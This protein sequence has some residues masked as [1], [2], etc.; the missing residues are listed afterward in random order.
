MLR[1]LD[2]FQFCQCFFKHP[3]LEGEFLRAQHKENL[4]LRFSITQDKGYLKKFVCNLETCKLS[5]DVSHD[6]DAAQ[7]NSEVEW[8]NN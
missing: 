6:A 7:I 5:E 3:S 8:S 4:E 1:R 2:K